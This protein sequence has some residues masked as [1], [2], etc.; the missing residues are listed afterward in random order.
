MKKLLRL[1]AVVAIAFSLV[2]CDQPNTEEPVDTTTTDTTTTTPT[3]PS[4]TT[5]ADTTT[6]SDTT[7][8]TDTTTTDD[9]TTPDD[10]TP[11]DYHVSSVT[12]IDELENST[13]YF[14][15]TIDSAQALQAL[16]LGNVATALTVIYKYEFMPYSEEANVMTGPK[17]G[18]FWN[19]FSLNFKDTIPA[20]EREGIIKGVSNYFDDDW[21]YWSTNGNKITV[22]I[23]QAS[24][25]EDQ[26]PVTIELSGVFENGAVKI[27]YPKEMAANLRMGDGSEDVQLTFAQCYILSYEGV[28][29]DHATTPFYMNESYELT[30]NTDYIITGINADLT[31]QGVETFISWAKKM[32]ED[33]PEG[34]TK[35]YL[36]GF[37]R[38]DGKIYSGALMANSDIARMGLVS[39][40]DYS[41][42]HNGYVMEFTA[43][44]EKKWDDYWDAY[45]YD[46]ENYSEPGIYYE[47]Y[48]LYDELS[49]ENLLTTYPDTFVNTDYRIYEK[50]VILNDA[51]L[52][53]WLQLG[54]TE[55]ETNTIYL[56]VYPDGDIDYIKDTELSQLTV[57]EDYSMYENGL[58]LSLT[59]EGDDK[60]DHIRHPE[61]DDPANQGDDPETGGDDTGDGNDNGTDYEGDGE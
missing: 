59:P 4:G 1:F 35:F 57:G 8:P 60:L 55:L 6:P 56:V 42:T 20:S 21:F 11:K 39:G 18:Y 5:P 7:T 53:K 48:F 52:A 24:E 26:D 10:N 61:I 36:A 43:S 58:V 51:G 2:A 28:I 3:T 31:N 32:D 47:G 33:L 37:K 45:Y 16:D 54:A 44:G 38:E 12:S 46:E 49:A 41:I 14:E 19:D 22:Y 29:I 23:D 9:T 30:I 40:T 25:D 15:T 34:E 17:P 13:W 50:S 27:T